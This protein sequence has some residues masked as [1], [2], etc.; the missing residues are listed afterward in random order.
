[1]NKFVEVTTVSS[2]V[3]VSFYPSELARFESPGPGGSW[4]GVGAYITLKCGRSIEARES[5]D[6]IKR[7]LREADQAAEYGS[8]MDSQV[9]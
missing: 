1:M 2:G 4:H 5:Y 3:K 7:M 8:V 9:K 6:S